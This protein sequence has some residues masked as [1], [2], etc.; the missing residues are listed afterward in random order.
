MIISGKV[1][2]GIKINITASDGNLKFKKTN[3][4]SKSKTLSA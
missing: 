4:K 1:S 3:I 2:D